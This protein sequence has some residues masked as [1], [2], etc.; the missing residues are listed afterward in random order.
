MHS[1]NSPVAPI[2][3]TELQKCFLIPGTYSGCVCCLLTPDFCTI[4]WWLGRAEREGLLGPAP[5]ILYRSYL[6]RPYYNP[7]GLRAVPRRWSLLRD[8]FSALVWLIILSLPHP[9]VQK[10]AKRCAKITLA[11]LSARF[12]SGS[13][14]SAH[15][16]T[17]RAHLGLAGCQFPHLRR[18]YWTAL[19]IA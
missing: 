11:H 10:C 7:Q 14:I 17:G 16:C 13:F 3:H 15:R 4:A 18:P 6:V 9:D 8:A 1:Q 19:S 12:C 2:A 5:R